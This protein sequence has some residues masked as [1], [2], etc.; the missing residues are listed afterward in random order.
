MRSVDAIL[1]RAGWLAC[2]AVLAAC[3]S[4]PPAPTPATLLV[5]TAP[6]TIAAAATPATVP[7]TPASIV[8]SPT[9]APVTTATSMPPTP[10][11]TPSGARIAVQVPDNSIQLVNL[12]GGTQL[13]YKAS[14]QVD[15]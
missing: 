12:A 6:T 14:S 7:S 15:L 1:R 8:P 10:V 3:T 9:A 13:L 11:P 2:V 4:R 5:T